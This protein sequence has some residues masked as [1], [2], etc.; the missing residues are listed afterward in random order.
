MTF[1]LGIFFV[2]GAGLQTAQAFT[3][4]RWGGIALHLLFA[5]MYLI[6]GLYMILAPMQAAVDITLVI[7]I[8]LVVV[9]VFRFVGSVGV[10]HPAWGASMLAGAV[11][12]LLGILLWVQW[13]FS[14]LFFIG[15][16]VAIDLIFAGTA[17]I[18][19]AVAVRDVQTARTS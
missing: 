2:V 8:Y 10:G 5:V 15:L 13:P 12:I 4:Q 1:I 14:G 9:G 18:V 7:A 17:W 3:T 6:A 16:C 11:N 19:F